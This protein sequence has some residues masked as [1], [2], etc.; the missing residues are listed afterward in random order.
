[1]RKETPACSVLWCD[2]NSRPRAAVRPDLCVGHKNRYVTH[3]DEVLGRALPGEPQ[4]WIDVVALKF[5]GDECLTWPFGRVN[6]YGLVRSP[7]G[8]R[9]FASAYI[10]ELAH[11]PPPAPYYEAAHWCGEG[12]RGCVNPR[13]IR[14]AT[15]K[16]NTADKVRH[17]THIRPPSNRGVSLFKDAT[18]QAIRDAAAAGDSEETI[19]ARMGVG[20]RPIRKI[21]TREWFGWLP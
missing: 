20:V 7:R 10:C 1:M 18:I 9:K 11:G 14:W 6:G 8:F 4:R 5:T 21:L 15:P 17:G 3:G 13:H 2:R 19:A 12:R 16:E